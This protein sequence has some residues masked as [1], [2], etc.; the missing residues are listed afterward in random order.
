MTSP[1]GKRK[2]L[3]TPDA[4][5]RTPSIQRS[6]TSGAHSSRLST[7]EQ[8]LTERHAEAHDHYERRLDKDDDSVLSLTKP[9]SEMLANDT[10]KEVRSLN[11][12]KNGE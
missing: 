6:G 2:R 4:D 12:I 8:I 9:L 11:I 7:T 10:H 1:D 3:S 5:I